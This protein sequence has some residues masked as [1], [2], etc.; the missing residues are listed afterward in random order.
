MLFFFNSGKGL[1]YKTEYEEVISFDRL[2]SPIQKEVKAEKREKIVVEGNEYN[3]DLI[4][5]YTIYGRVVDT[6]TYEKGEGIQTD[7]VPKDVGLVWGPMAQNKFK[8]LFYFENKLLPAGRML[9]V[10]PKNAQASEIFKNLGYSYL[11][12]NHILASDEKTEQLIYRIK[13][14]DYIKIEGYLCKISESY[15]KQLTPNIVRER[16]YV[17]AESSI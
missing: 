2:P 8:N 12:N 17:F 7:V 5:E 15:F 16:E 13:K 3:V 1:K 9:K 6:L 14:N 4:Y 10:I 11:S